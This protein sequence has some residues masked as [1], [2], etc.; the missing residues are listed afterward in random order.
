MK[1]VQKMVEKDNEI[2]DMNDAANKT[3]LMQCTEWKKIMEGW[4]KKY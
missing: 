2:V 4:L 1:A 3:W